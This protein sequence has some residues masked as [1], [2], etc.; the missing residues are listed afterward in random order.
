MTEWLTL[1]WY[2]KRRDWFIRNSME[3]S[4]GIKRNRN[5]D[6]NRNQ[7]RKSTA[8][9]H[10]IIIIANTYILMLHTTHFL[11]TVLWY[12]HNYSDYF[13]D[14]KENAWRGYFSKTKQLVNIYLRTEFLNFEARNFEFFNFIFIFIFIYFSKTKQ[15]VN[16][17]LRTEFLNFEARKPGSR[18]SL[19]DHDASL[20]WYAQLMTYHHLPF[21][22]LCFT[23]CLSRVF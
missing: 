5:L 8:G 18:I 6:F 17:Y 22:L 20:P 13:R 7:N 3:Y 10:I 12:R 2:N 14:E 4:I 15:L 23:I 1:Y 16:I 21:F 9:F 11:K 19:L